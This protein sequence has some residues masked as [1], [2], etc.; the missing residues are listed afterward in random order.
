MKNLAFFALALLFLASCQK[1]ELQDKAYELSFGTLNYEQLD[2]RDPVPAD[3][4]VDYFGNRYQE[5]GDLRWDNQD[6]YH[7]WSAVQNSTSDAVIAVGYKPAGVD[8]DISDIIQ[9]VDVNQGEWLQVRKALV[10]YI[11]LELKADPSEVIVHIDNTL[12][13][14]E[15]RTDNYDLIAKLRRCEQVRYV[16]PLDYNLP[17]G[18]SR[19]SFGCDG[20][21]ATL[22]SADYVTVSPGAKVPWSFYL[23]NIPAAWAHAQGDNITVG[24]I[25]AGFSSSQ[26]SLNAGFDDGWSTGRSVS[27]DYTRGSSAF[28]GCAHGT[29]MA[30]LVAAPRNSLGNAVGV[31]YKANIVAMRASDDVVL[32]GWGERGDVRDALK[33]LGDN[34]QVRIISM[35]LGW[36]FGSSYLRDGVDY[37][38]GKGKLVFAAAGTSF[39]WTSWWGVIYPARYSSAVAVTGLMENNSLCDECHWGSQV[40]FTVA[41]QRDNSSDRRTFAL[42]PSGNTPSYVGGSSSATA[43]TA[44]IAALVWSANPSLTNSQV[45]NILKQSGE[46]YPFR[47]SNRGYGKV[48]A[49]QAVQMAKSLL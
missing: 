9:D 45:L 3:R 25:D 6:D 5:E 35:S 24:V 11:A 37:A 14:I 41:M 40:D 4:L 47:N 7:L 16:E 19:S 27:F 48:D 23:N 31:A 13:Q 32:N 20:S 17:V 29:S 39:D 22:N 8:K 42:S 28:N 30:G 2:G 12:P 1:E 10:D 49:L 33:R 43:T 34:N 46:Y 21:S 18:S 15:V 44:G 36:I 26:F 38:N